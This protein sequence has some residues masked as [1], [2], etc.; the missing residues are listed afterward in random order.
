M[1][2]TTTSDLLELHGDSDTSWTVPGRA[3]DLNTSEVEAYPNSAEPPINFVRCPPGTQ[4]LNMAERGQKRLLLFA[5]LSLHFGRLSM[6]GRK[7]MFLAAEAQLDFHPMPRSA[8]PA[9]RD[10]CRYEGRSSR[11]PSCLQPSWANAAEQGGPVEKTRKLYVDTRGGE[12]THRR[13]RWLQLGLHQ[14]AF[15]ISGA[16]NSTAMAHHGKS[17]GN[18][19]MLSSRDGHPRKFLPAALASVSYVRVLVRVRVC[20]LPRAQESSGV[21]A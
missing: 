18:P 21:W 7:G 6:E 2:R 20:E 10:I 15:S 17:H 9:L 1:R 14:K 5:N 8:V 19:E 3:R 12:P 13:L 4:S 16:Q 11:Q